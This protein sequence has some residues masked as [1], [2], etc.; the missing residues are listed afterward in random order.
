MSYAPN[1][2][3]YWIDH[4]AEWRTGTTPEDMTWR[5]VA[6]ILEEQIATID[7][8]HAAY[9]MRAEIAEQRYKDREHARRLCKVMLLELEQ[10]GASPFVLAQFETIIGTW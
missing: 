6:R 4:I 9:V 10:A 2:A 7:S 5:A 8:E 1:T 3:R